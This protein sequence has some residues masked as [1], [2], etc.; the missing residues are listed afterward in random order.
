MCPWICAARQLPLANFLRRYKIQ[1]QSEMSRTKFLCRVNTV[2]YSKNEVTFV[3]NC[4]FMENKNV[5]NI[6]LFKIE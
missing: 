3:R 2:L 6:T 1:R 5:G 4:R